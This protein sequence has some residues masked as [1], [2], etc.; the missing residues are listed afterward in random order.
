MKPLS[1]FPW[2][3]ALWIT[4]SKLQLW[5][6]FTCQWSLERWYRLP[7]IGKMK[8]IRLQPFEFLSDL[9]C[10]GVSHLLNITLDSL[11]VWYMNGKSIAIKLQ[12][13]NLHCWEIK[14]ES[15]SHGFQNNDE[16]WQK[17]IT[18]VK[19]QEQLKGL[20]GSSFQTLFLFTYTWFSAGYM[21][22]VAPQKLVSHCL[23]QQ[24]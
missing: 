24:P 20:H 1:N 19:G 7:E 13:S 12:W 22:S 15:E 6:I 11:V 14:T 18:M 17:T 8:E 21:R 2:R 9:I 3:K 10:S 4:C 5:H 16:R 23:R